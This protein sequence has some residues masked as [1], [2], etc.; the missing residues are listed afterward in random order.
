MPPVIRATETIDFARKYYGGKAF[1]A[2]LAKCRRHGFAHGSELVEALGY[3]A[4]NVYAA[5]RCL[6]AAEAAGLIVRGEA[7]TPTAEQRFF[8]VA[9]ARA[10]RCAKE[11]RG[12]VEYGWEPKK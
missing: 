8:N 11:L 7:P 9:A 4:D 3:K 1:D 6:L 12:P 10:K 2:W 5:E